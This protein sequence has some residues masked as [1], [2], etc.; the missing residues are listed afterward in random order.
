MMKFDVFVDS[1]PKICKFL[2][3]AKVL[4]VV[5]R[6]I[7]PT[8]IFAAVVVIGTT[9][10]AADS[11]ELRPVVVGLNCC[12]LSGGGVWGFRRILLEGFSSNPSDSFVDPRKRMM[13]VR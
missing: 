7:T 8:A 5:E 2:A 4:M 13:A 10:P 9:L 3:G 1:N 12:H 11:E 6:P